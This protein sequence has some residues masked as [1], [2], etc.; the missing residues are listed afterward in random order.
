MIRLNENFPQEAPQFAS[1]IV[2]ETE[3]V[4]IWAKLVVH[5]LIKGLEDGDDLDELHATL[6]A[7]PSDLRDLYT[8]MFAKMDL[9]YQ[10]ESA[11]MFRLKE[12]WLSIAQSHALPGLIIWYAINNPAASLDRPLGPIPANQYDWGMSSL[13]KRVQSRCCKLLELRD[14]GRTL[15]GLVKIEVVGDDVFIEEVNHFS[16]DYLHRTVDE[17]ITV[18]DVWQQIYDLTRDM[19]FD[20][21]VRLASASLSAMKLVRTTATTTNRMYAAIVALHCREVVDRSTEVEHGYFVEL[22]RIMTELN[23]RLHTDESHN[24]VSTACSRQYWSQNAGMIAFAAPVNI[25]LPGELNY[26]SMYTYATGREILCHPS[27]ARLR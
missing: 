1:E 16:I 4:S 27:H 11:V 3:G 12:K 20:I 14:K 26:T 25:I 13:V 21:S 5:M 19:L 24:C 9:M 23:T 15:D 10:K 18:D 7:L 17:F 8:R 22:D 2:N 6:S